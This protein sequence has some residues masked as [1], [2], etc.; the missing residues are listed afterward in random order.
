MVSVLILRI[1]CVCFFLVF[2]FS[3]RRRHT[4]CALVTGVQTC[5]LPILVTTFMTTPILALLRPDM[6]AEVSAAAGDDDGSVKVLVHVASMDNAY[7]L[8]H[9][10]LAS[11]DVEDERIQVVLLRTLHVGNDHV[12]AAPVDGSAV[13]RAERSLRPLAQFVEGSGASDVILAVHTTELARAV[14]DGA[15]ELAVDAVVLSSRRPFSPS[16]L[17][18]GTMRRIP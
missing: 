11:V 10:A 9:T 14:I 1:F 15:E 7:E 18:G 5:A 12:L 3:S 17:G 13:D 2:F 16:G 4:R 8:I 6:D